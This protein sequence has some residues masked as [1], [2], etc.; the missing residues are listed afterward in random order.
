MS[1]FRF[2]KSELEGIGGPYLDIVK[3][4]DPVQMIDLLCASHFFAGRFGNKIP[5]SEARTAFLA[6]LAKHDAETP[7]LSKASPK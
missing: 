7:N 3:I 5:V 2:K 1:K 6:W 4:K